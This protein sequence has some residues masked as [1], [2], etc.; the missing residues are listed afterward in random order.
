MITQ[1]HDVWRSVTDGPG[2]AEVITGGRGR[3][4]RT[5]R[6]SVVE[7]HHDPSV[8]PRAGDTCRR[9]PRLPPAT[10]KR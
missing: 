2:T 9:N 8:V 5:T 6:F 10:V 3:D 7:H 4:G 1:R